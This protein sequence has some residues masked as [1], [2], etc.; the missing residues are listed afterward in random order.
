MIHEDHWSCFSV[1]PSFQLCNNQHTNN[2]PRDK[3]HENNSYRLF[4]VEPKELK[5]NLLSD[6]SG[7]YWEIGKKTDLLS[8]QPLPQSDPLSQRAFS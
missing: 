5:R 7:L 1:Q 3:L 8:A 4:Q 2:S 6:W